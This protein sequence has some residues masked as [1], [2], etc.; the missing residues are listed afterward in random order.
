MFVLRISSANYL[1]CWLNLHE[2]S[3]PRSVSNTFNSCLSVVLSLVEG[4]HPEN[5]QSVCVKINKRFCLKKTFMCLDLR[6]KVCARVS[7]Q[8]VQCLLSI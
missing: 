3:G 7:I 4:N 5:L 2:R 1:P 6:Q 8:S